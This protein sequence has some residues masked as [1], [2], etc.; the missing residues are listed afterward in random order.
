MATFDEMDPV[1]DLFPLPHEEEWLVSI[2]DMELRDRLLLRIFRSPP[3]ARADVQASKLLLDCDSSTGDITQIVSMEFA[4]AF[5]TREGAGKDSKFFLHCP[6][7]PAF[8]RSYTGDEIIDH[9]CEYFNKGA[10]RFKDGHED[11]DGDDDDSEDASMPSSASS[12]LTQASSFAEEVACSP[13]QVDPVEAEADVGLDDEASRKDLETREASIRPQGVGEGDSVCEEP[14]VRHESPPS[15]GCMPTCLR[16]SNEMRSGAR[17]NFPRK[18]EGCSRAT[19]MNMSNGGTTMIIYDDMYW[20]GFRTEYIYE[21]ESK[22]E[23]SFI[24]ADEDVPSSERVA[25]LLTPTNGSPPDCFLFDERAL[26]KAA[27][28]G[29][30]WFTRIVP[31][32]GNLTFGQKYSMPRLLHEVKTGMHVTISGRVVRLIPTKRKEVKPLLH[33]S[34]VFTLLGVVQATLTCQRYYWVAL[35]LGSKCEEAS[36]YIASLFDK[37]GG[38]H[39]TPIGSFDDDIAKYSEWFAKVKVMYSRETPRTLL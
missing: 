31:A 37:D 20:A 23:L 34:T 12:P 11:S 27:Q 25:M 8:N 7:F 24:V 33:T 2:K 17:I 10:L 18:D 1:A 15:A 5:I 28:S 13:R 38:A 39:I 14:P 29:W 6:S 32:P 35:Q 9:L 22:G 30:R 19:V 26:G 36:V 4:D 3:C 16:S 21:A